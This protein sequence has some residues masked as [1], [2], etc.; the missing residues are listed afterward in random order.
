M[1]PREGRAWARVRQFRFDAFGSE[2]GLLEIRTGAGRAD[3][4]QARHVVAVVAAD[5]P[6]MPL[7]MH[8]ERH[9]AVRA[10][11]RAGALTAENSRREPAAAQKPQGLF[12]PFDAPAAA[13]SDR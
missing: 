5:S 2:S 8:D 13:L 4:R 10:I 6:R 12:A 7:S 11:Q 9:A 1:Q 3:L